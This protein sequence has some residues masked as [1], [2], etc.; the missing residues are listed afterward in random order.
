MMWMKK[1]CINIYVKNDEYKKGYTKNSISNQD[2]LYL[3]N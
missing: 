2:E 3:I 1:K